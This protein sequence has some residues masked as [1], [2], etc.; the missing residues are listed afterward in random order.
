MLFKGI[1]GSPVKRYLVL[2][3][4]SLVLVSL[5]GVL[6]FFWQ[7]HHASIGR[8]EATAY[9]LGTANHVLAGIEILQ[10]IEMSVRLEVVTQTDAS[11]RALPTDLVRLVADKAYLMRQHVD[12]IQATQVAFANPAYD[13]FARR[14]PDRY[15]AFVATIDRMAEGEISDTEALMAQLDVL[16][17]SLQQLE[18][19]HID[20]YEQLSLRMAED[21]R[22]NVIQLVAL[23]LVLAGVGLFALLRGLRLIEAGQR[24]EKQALEISARLGRIMENLWNEILVFEADTC[25]FV[26]VNR[27]ALKNIGYTLQEMYDLTVTDI[28]PEFDGENFASLVAPLRAAEKDFLLFEA[29]QQR[30]DGTDYAVEVRLQLLSNEAPPVFVAVVN[31]ITERK[32]AEQQLSQLNEE[33][34]QRV[35]ERTAQLQ[36]S[37]AELTQTLDD[38]RRAQDQLIESE[39]MASLGGLVAGVAHEINTPVGIGVTAASHLNDQVHDLVRSF[40]DGNLRRSDLQRFVET[41]M[42]STEIVLSNLQRA[43]ELI[44]SFKQVAVDQ[45]NEDRRCFLLKTYLEEIVQSLAPQL[46]KKSHTLTVRCDDGIVFDGFPGT[47]AQ[48][49]TNLVINAII[50]GFDER[51]QGEITI[52]VSEEPDR[53][54]LVV[55]DNGAGMSK[56]VRARI[57]DPFFTTKRNAGGT[58]LGMHIVFNLVSQKLG[59]NI[60]C[61]SAPNEGT[62]FTITLPHQALRP[63]A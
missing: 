29:R 1:L 44:R 21:D 4:T 30:K 58:G 12:A 3:T 61:K 41:A 8:Q 28:M 27:G 48:I 31:D 52:D 49:I 63:A 2:L 56:E 51:A 20:G 14:T 25:R 15:R 60:D 43:S 33:L 50:H 37:N 32:K 22:Q 45:S 17:I 55:S 9:H 35:V 26:Q 36:S 16:R 19:L 38:L 6:L 59:G 54:R 5:S 11:M 53:L 46:K 24:R 13:G 10:D 62:Q 42:S 39:K 57:F 47:L 34:E 7:A 40:S 23:S 18:E